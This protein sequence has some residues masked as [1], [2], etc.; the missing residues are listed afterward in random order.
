MGILSRIIIK[1]L[2]VST[3]GERFFIFGPEDHDT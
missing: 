1:Y 3:G 2:R